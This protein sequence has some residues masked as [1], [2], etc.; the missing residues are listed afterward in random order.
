MLHLPKDP[1]TINLLKDYGKKIATKLKEWMSQKDESGKSIWDRC[2][3]FLKE[4]IGER[5]KVAVSPEALKCALFYVEKHTFSLSMTELVAFVKGQYTLKQGDRIAVYR[6][7]EDG[8]ELLEVMAIDTEGNPIISAAKPWCR[9]YVGV[10]DASL[11]A[12]FGNKSLLV[13]Q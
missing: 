5:A 10:L 4:E 8:N 2:M 9:I 7:I 13:L 3:D 11:Q 6:N 1:T 12:A